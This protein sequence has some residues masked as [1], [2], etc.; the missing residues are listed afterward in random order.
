MPNVLLAIDRECL[1]S[2]SVGT[3]AR[4]PRNCASQ[5]DVQTFVDA[6]SL[7]EWPCRTARRYARD[8]CRILL[9]K[10][11]TRP[12]RTGAEEAAR[13][14]QGYVGLLIE[15]RYLLAGLHK[16]ASFCSRSS[17]P[18]GISLSIST[19]HRQ[20]RPPC[21]TSFS[22]KAQGGDGNTPSAI[23][24]QSKRRPRVNPAPTTC[25]RG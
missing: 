11:M 15:E 22:R 9:P 4:D 24:R 8:G 2:G 19:S 25:E 3:G 16:R 23:G 5:A 10:T 7:M 18:S 13:Q 6:G 1:C 21:Q 14:G 20:W 17:T 12:T